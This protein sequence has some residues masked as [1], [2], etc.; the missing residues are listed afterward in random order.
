[1]VTSRAH[2]V[3]NLWRPAVEGKSTMPLNK[4]DLLHQLLDVLSVLRIGHIRKIAE[5]PAILKP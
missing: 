2:R 1:M 4:L 5:H 3:H